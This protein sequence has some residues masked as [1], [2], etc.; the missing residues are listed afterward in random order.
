MNIDLGNPVEQLSN[1]RCT[2]E[3]FRSALATGKFK[4][5]DI[6]LAL[7]ETFLKQF[8]QM[9]KK[10]G[11]KKLFSKS[12]FEIKR[13]KQLLGRG[14]KLKKDEVVNYERFIPNCKFIKNDNRFSPQGVEWLYLSMGKDWSKVKECAIF[15]CRAEKGS[16]FALCEFMINPIV[17]DYKVVDLTISGDMTYD[18]IQRGLE[19]KLEKIAGRKNLIL[20]V[21]ENKI[22]DCIEKNLVMY[23]SK[24]IAD[25]IFE[26]VDSDNKEYMYA[27]FHCIAQYFIKCGYQG[28]I[29]PSTVCD[30]GRNIVFFD[31]NYASPTDKIRKFIV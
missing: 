11:Q 4:Y 5:D 26:P 28:I 13:E 3:D 21:K 10:A 19:S 12:I 18:D 14:A 2:W 15:E 17:Y 23:L 31:K 8:D 24:L 1:Y 25:G 27:P 6:D 7:N 9:F 29:Y 20:N 30:G 22:R 16:I